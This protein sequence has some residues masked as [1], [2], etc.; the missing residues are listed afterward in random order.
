ML[1]VETVKRLTVPHLQPELSQLLRK[2]VP[3]FIISSLLWESTK[4]CYLTSCA[5]HVVSDADGLVVYN[6][7]TAVANRKL[8]KVH[9]INS[10]RVQKNP[11]SSDSFF[12]PFHC[13][14][15]FNSILASLFV[16]S[17]TIPIHGIFLGQKCRCFC[18]WCRWC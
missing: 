14:I 17:A 16:I 11:S 18:R 2:V 10:S 9:V 1:Q 8:C 7:G 6:V 13:F 15:D 3:P 12:L 5:S 4:C